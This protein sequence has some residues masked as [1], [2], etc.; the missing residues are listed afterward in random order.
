[1]CGAGAGVL[2]ARFRGRRKA[3][4]AFLLGR[5]HCYSTVE[6]ARSLL[7]LPS[8]RSERANGE[9]RRDLRP[10][11]DLVAAHG[12]VRAH[13]LIAAHVKV[14]LVGR[15]LAR[16]E[17]LRGAQNAACRVSPGCVEKQV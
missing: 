5:R 9:V 17:G 1:V 12:H 2:T 3:P 6:V 10:H 14:T 7:L 8:D 11:D 4:L 16:R 13:H 15:A